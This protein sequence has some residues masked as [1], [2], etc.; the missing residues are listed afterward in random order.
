MPRAVLVAPLL[1]V[2]DSRLVFLPITQL[3][4]GPVTPND[5]SADSIPPQQRLSRWHPRGRVGG[6]MLAG[7]K[8]TCPA[9]PWEAASLKDTVAVSATGPV[10][11]SRLREGTS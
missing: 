5:V 2:R 10:V 1:L 9:W 11:S 6:Q 8:E 3:V 4:D 7:H